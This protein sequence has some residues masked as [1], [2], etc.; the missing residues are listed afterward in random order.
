[1]ALRH[2]IVA[3]MSCAVA[4]CAPGSVG[5]ADAY[6]GDISRSLSSFRAGAWS[7]RVD[8]AWVGHAGDAQFPSDRLAE[9]AYDPVVAG[10]TYRVVLS[11]GGNQV[12]VGETPLLGQRTRTTDSLVE[13]TLSKGTFAGGR[14]V[15]WWSNDGLQGELTIYGSGRPI[16]K[17]ERGCV[18]PDS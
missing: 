17:S 11:D 18:V 10:L 15:V 12:A 4:S 16:V 14:F 6:P 8:R 7:F 9:P 1:M 2:L 3:V 13:Y 5:G